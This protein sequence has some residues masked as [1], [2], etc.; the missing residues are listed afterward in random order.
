MKTTI[1]LVILIFLFAGIHSFGQE[2]RNPF[3]PDLKIIDNIV[4]KKIDTEVLEMLAF[5]PQNDNDELH[6]CL[7][8]L[9]GGGWGK[10]DRYRAK[11]RDVIE[12]IR[13]LSNKNYISFSIEYRLTDV[14]KG[15][16]AMESVADCKD[17]VRYIIKN[18]EKWNIDPTKIS[19][20]GTSAGAHLAMVTALAPDSEF[21]VD[22]GLKDINVEVN[23]AIS[24]YGPTSFINED[25][26]IGNFKNPSRMIPILGGLLEDKME[27]A[28]NLSPV[29]WMS[30]DMPA[31]ML[32]HGITDST[33]S[34][35]HAEYMK[36]NADINDFPVEMILVEGAGHGFKGDNINPDLGTIKN[37]TVRFILENNK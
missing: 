23:S 35:K 34:Y 20:F 25:L 29:E 18:S 7:I 3:P 24:Y 36:A 4:Y 30:N 6:P 12:V 16:T 22:P 9:H 37:K 33:V 2:P 21:E 8:Y 15:I 1:N 10:G 28:K 11:R 13:D 26:S 19:L 14:E 32:V 27:V 17:A 31:V 5:M